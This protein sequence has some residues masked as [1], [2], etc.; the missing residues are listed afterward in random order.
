MLRILQTGQ[1]EISGLAEVRQ[2]E[3]VDVVLAANTSEIPVVAATSS[4][5]DVSDEMVK[6]KEHVFEQSSECDENV[7]PC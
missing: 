1:E 3:E 5:N 4:N 7:Y 2:S 6:S